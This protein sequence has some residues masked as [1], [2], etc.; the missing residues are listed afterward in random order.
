MDNWQA[1]RDV[2]GKDKK[3]RILFK[4]MQVYKIK[5][6]EVQDSP[7]NLTLQSEERDWHLH[8]TQLF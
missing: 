5:L 8:S 6:R 7:Q 3:R 2:N 4:L 1:P